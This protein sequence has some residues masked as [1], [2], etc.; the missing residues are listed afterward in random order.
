V[1]PD[2]A[3]PELAAMISRAGDSAG[4]INPLGFALTVGAESPPIMGAV[5]VTFPVTVPSGISAAEQM[6]VNSRATTD[7][8][9]SITKIFFMF[10]SFHSNFS[11]KLYSQLREIMQSIKKAPIYQALKKVDRI[12]RPFLIQKTYYCV[13]LRA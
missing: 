12:G 7:I 8:I 2:F 9:A 10:L 5:V 3:I 4:E 13:Q 1:S 11:A 6:V